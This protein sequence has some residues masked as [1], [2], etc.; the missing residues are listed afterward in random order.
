MIS[1]QHRFFFLLGFILASMGSSQSSPRTLPHYCWTCWLIEHIPVV[2]G[3]NN[4]GVSCPKKSRYPIGEKPP[5]ICDLNRTSQQKKCFRNSQINTDCS[6]NPAWCAKAYKPIP[7]TNSK[8][9]WGFAIMCDPNTYLWI[10]K[11][12]MHR[13]FICASHFRFAYY[14]VMPLPHTHD[15]A[16][17]AFFHEHFYDNP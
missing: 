2:I 11:M 1:Q 7:Q 10:T 12:F 14:L 9:E 5:H 15:M 13:I 6:T 8:A 17:L 4:V 16:N 3:W